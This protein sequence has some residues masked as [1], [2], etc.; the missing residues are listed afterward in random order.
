[1]L[2]GRLEETREAAR[3]EMA[4]SSLAFWQHSIQSST[5]EV[6]AH[7]DGAMN[8]HELWCPAVN[9]FTRYAHEIVRD[10]SLLTEGDRL[11]LHSL[12]VLWDLMAASTASM[13]LRAAVQI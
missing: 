11:V 5:C 4:K 10:P 13:P 2:L 9:P 12:G 8:Q 7:C 3:F 1:M 6:C